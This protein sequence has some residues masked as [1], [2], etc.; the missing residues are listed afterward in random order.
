MK[1]FGIEHEQWCAFAYLLFN[2]ESGNR[3]EVMREIGLG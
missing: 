3:E 1:K 2:E